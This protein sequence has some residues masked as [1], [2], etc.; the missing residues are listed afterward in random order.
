MT[1]GPGNLWF[2]LLKAKYFLSSSHLFAS[3]SGG[4]QFWRQL[5]T[6]R[7]EF[8]VQVNLWLIME[9]PLVFGLTGGLATTPSVKLFLPFFVMFL[10]GHFHL[11]TCC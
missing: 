8:S 1:S 2:Y 5:V 9:S 6:M 11:E 10:A 7:D 4:S 3:A